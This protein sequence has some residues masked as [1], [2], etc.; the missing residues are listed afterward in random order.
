MTTLQPSSTA[1][2]NTLWIFSEEGY[3]WVACIIR[4]LEA[5]RTAIA[6]RLYPDNLHDPAQPEALEVAT[7]QAQMIR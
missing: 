7:D 1:P 5:L 3:M 2:P 6:W 4:W